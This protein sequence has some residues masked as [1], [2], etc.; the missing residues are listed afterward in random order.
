MF[1]YHSGADREMQRMTPNLAYGHDKLAGD[2]F[3][4]SLGIFS[5]PA[6]QHALPRV[7]NE[8]ELINYM[9]RKQAA[10]TA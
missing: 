4:A 3:R 10:E 9:G 8:T 2:A 7:S 5:K 1:S 6:R